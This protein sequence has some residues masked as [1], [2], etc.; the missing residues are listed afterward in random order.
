MLKNAPITSYI[1]VADV[2]PRAAVLRG[3]VGAGAQGRLCGRRDLRMRRGGRC[4][5]CIRQREPGTSKASQAFWTVDDVEAE[6]AELKG[7]GV[8]FEEYGHAGAQNP[9]QHRDRRWR[10]DG[11][12]QGHRRKHPGRQPTDLLLNS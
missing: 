8:V 6:V 5:S 7:R 1:P 3:D 9:E 11:V 10:E 2:G 12:V 4:S